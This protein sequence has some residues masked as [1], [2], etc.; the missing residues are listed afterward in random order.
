VVAILDG[1]AEGAQQ[2]AYGRRATLGVDGSDGGSTGGDQN[3]KLKR[4]ESTRNQSKHQKTIIAEKDARKD[5]DLNAIRERFDSF[6][7]S[8]LHVIS[9]YGIRL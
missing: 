5:C 4:G 1:L 2:I 3:R 7:S 6:T 8:D 9:K